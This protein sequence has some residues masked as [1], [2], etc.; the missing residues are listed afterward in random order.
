MNIQQVKTNA[1]LRNTTLFIVNFLFLLS[2]GAQTIYVDVDASGSDDGSSWNNAYTSLRTALENAD[3]NAEIWVAGGTYRAEGRKDYLI[4]DKT[5]TIYGGFSGTETSPD[6]RDLIN[7]TTVLNGDVMGDDVSTNQ[8]LNKEDNSIHVLVV[9]SGVSGIVL[10]GLRI[11]GG[12][13]ERT[14]AS[15]MDL[16]DYSGAGILNLGESIEIRNCAFYNNRAD[17]FGGAI[18]SGATSGSSLTLENCSFDNNLAN[19]DGGDICVRVSE[20]VIDISDC[21]FTNSAGL[22]GGCIYLKGEGSKLSVA[23]SDFIDALATGLGAGIA[24]ANASELRIEN[25]EF[26]ENWAI[27]GGGGLYIEEVTAVF[28]L[29]SIFEANQVT[30]SSPDG[31]G[32]AIQCF[33]PE[34]SVNLSEI[35]LEDC[36]LTNNTSGFIGGAIYAERVTLS[37]NGTEIMANSAEVAGGGV[38]TILGADLSLDETNIS[39]NTAPQGAGVYLQNEAQY[40]F[41]NSTFSGN[42]ASENGGGLFADI[43]GNLS[44]DNC[45]FSENEATEGGGGIYLAAGMIMIENSSFSQNLASYG[46]AISNNG[47]DSKIEISLTD[48]MENMATVD[49]AALEAFEGGVYQIF[50]SEFLRNSVN[51]NG[52]AISLASDNIAGVSH[53]IDASVFEGN[54]AKGN[55]ADQTGY[56]SAIV[57]FNTSLKL[58]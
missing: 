22:N 21:T 35:T 17:D 7:N 14:T 24:A 15:V 19:A 37:V 58:T 39:D 34:G 50:G 20:A 32:G 54:E 31:R 53:F 52:G 3:V 2:L 33:V 48:F 12:Y 16:N 36:R 13:T 47:E 42:N 29:E 44:I 40:N 27:R 11:E 43:D 5:V 10:D 51:G 4:I 26:R 55:A 45:Q 6:E 41:V 56:G 25:C 28:I 49:G 30:Q 8:S 1:M 38:I 23:R 9:E 18:F 57:S 46:G